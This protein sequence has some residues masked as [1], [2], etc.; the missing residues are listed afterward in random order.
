[1]L[2]TLAKGTLYPDNPAK[3][4]EL[5]EKYKEYIIPEEE[6]IWYG[7]TIKEAATKQKKIEDEENKPLPLK[8]AFR[9]EFIEYL[10]SSANVPDDTTA[11]RDK[12]SE[13]SSWLSK[14]NPF[15]KK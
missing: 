10:K 6:A 2:L 13:K 7:L 12:M 14:V 9:K 15:V 8:Y 1:M 11:T 4:E 5:I 3:K